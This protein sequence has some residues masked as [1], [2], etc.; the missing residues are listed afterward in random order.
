MLIPEIFK[1]SGFGK[2]KAIVFG[3][4]SATN[5]SSMGDR[6]V[7]LGLSEPERAA[8][9][10]CLGSAIVLDAIIFNLNLHNSVAGCE[11]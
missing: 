10:D 6:R 9:G 4:E 3:E 5:L 8:A 2:S 11:R 7:F 1:N